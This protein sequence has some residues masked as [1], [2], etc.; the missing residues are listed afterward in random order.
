LVRKK[1]AL[2][3]SYSDGKRGVLEDWAVRYL[4][5]LLIYFGFI[6]STF[7]LLFGVVSAVAASAQGC[8]A[9]RLYLGS[10]RIQ[11]RIQTVHCDRFV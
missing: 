5:L 3:D 9:H 7:L 1:S 4:H 8:I 11:A 2:Q 10:M 6:A